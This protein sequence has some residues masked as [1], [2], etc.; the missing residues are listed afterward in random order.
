[1]DDASGGDTEAYGRRATLSPLWA[2]QLWRD[3]SGRSYGAT[4]LSPV[5]YGRKRRVL[6]RAGYRSGRH[7]SLA[8]LSNMPLW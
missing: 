6:Q 2:S 4:H 3:A 7:T 8:T 5:P 1:V